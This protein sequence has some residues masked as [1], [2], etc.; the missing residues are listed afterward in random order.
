MA[1]IF[2]RTLIIYV[3]IVFS[4]R[5]MGKRQ[6]GELAP[7]ELVITILISSV[8][9]IP[10]QNNTT[11]LSTSL[12]PIAILISLEILQSVISMKSL[13]FRYFMQGRPI[14]IIKNGVLQQKA[15]KTLRLTLDDVLDA[16]RQQ[17]VFDINEVQNAIIETNGTLSVQKKSQFDNVTPNLINKKAQKATLPIAII[18]DGEKI[19]EYF[20]DEKI[21]TKTIDKILKQ[22][23]IQISDIMYM[24]ID[25]T[26]NC[27][28]IKKD[29]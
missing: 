4:L 1:I 20:K 14:F 8:A 6:L 24:S 21:S 22:N 26:N 27:I 2:V 9:T 23:K 29:E 3:S 12:V 7:H 28:I 19:S 25:E 18:I 15:F 5:F 11:P 13:K 17:G 10:L 16:L